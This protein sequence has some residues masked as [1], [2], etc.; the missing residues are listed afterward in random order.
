M[1]LWRVSIN[2]GDF[3]E[4][5]A[6]SAAHAASDVCLSYMKSSGERREIDLLIVRKAERIQIPPVK[7]M[8]LDGRSG[9]AGD[10]D[11]TLVDFD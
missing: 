8:V 5:E 4:V 7:A 1:T 3:E 10:P 6:I 2:A 9:W 11:G